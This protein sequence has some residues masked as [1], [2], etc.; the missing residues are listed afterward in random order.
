VFAGNDHELPEVAAHVDGVTAAVAPEGIPLRVRVVSAGKLVPLAGAR[1][2]VN[3]AAPPGA[4]VCVVSVV[5]PGVL[6]L[7]SATT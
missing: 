6:M 2:S 1:L 5:E 7:K 3:V 4:A